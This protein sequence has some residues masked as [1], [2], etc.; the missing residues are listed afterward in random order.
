MAAGPFPWFVLEGPPELMHK[1]EAEAGPEIEAWRQAVTDHEAL[2][3]NNEKMRHR[4]ELERAFA[5]VKRVYLR[6]GGKAPRMELS[7]GRRRK[8]YLTQAETSVFSRRSPMCLLNF[9]KPARRTN[10]GD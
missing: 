10:R 3:T 6:L 4:P 8:A 1:L 2:E 5:A 7:N 9:V